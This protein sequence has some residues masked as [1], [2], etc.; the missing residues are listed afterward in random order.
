MAVATRVSFIPNDPMARA[1]PAR[2]IAPIGFPA[3]AARFDVRPTAPAGLYAVHTP[4]FD[5]WQ[6]QTA[7]VL[8]T[9]AWKALDGTYLPRWF[10]NKAV[11]P[12]RTN[13]GDDLN[14]FYD[15]HSL[16][17]FSHTFKGRTVHSC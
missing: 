3:G 17:F 8:G 4:Q 16:Q 7:L 5:F 10:G 11:L 14:A 13:A 6:T 2:K 15:R 1:A 12:A 9:R